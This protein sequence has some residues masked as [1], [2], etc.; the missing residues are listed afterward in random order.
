[1]I[2]E[3]VP[4]QTVFVCMAIFRSWVFVWSDRLQYQSKTILLYHLV[5]PISMI[6]LPNSYYSRCAAMIYYCFEDVC[7]WISHSDQTY[8]LEVRLS[9]LLVS[10]T[11][12]H[13]VVGHT[14]QHSVWLL[15]DQPFV[16][17]IALLISYHGV[18]KQGCGTGALWLTMW[19]HLQQLE[20]HLREIWKW[21]ITSLHTQYIIN[22][23]NSSTPH[24]GN[25]TR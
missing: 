13:H 21:I 12:T 7:F 2:V 3:H 6:Q 1:M 17:L 16:L 19:Y 22:A 10:Q 9:Q 4:T 20:C 18:L 11:M 5:T 14:L 8:E 23:I 24:T 25:I 15:L